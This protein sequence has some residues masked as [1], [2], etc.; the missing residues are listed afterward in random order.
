MKLTGNPTIFSLNPYEQETV[1]EHPLGA[2]GIGS[3]GD[4]YRY[5]KINAAG[6]DLIAGKLVVSRGR[7][8][9]HQNMTLSAVAA[10]GAK[11]LLPTAGA[12]AVDANEYDEG[13]LA[14]VDTS[15]EGET[16]TITAHEAN[17]GS[18]VTDFYIYPGLLTVTTAAAEVSVVRNVWN[19]P[20]ISQLIAEMAAGIPLSDWD[21]SVAGFGWLKTRGIVAGFGDTT[22]VTVG[23]RMTVSDQVDGAIGLLSDLDS[24]QQVGIAMEASVNGELQPVY[25]TID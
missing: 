12:T 6:T 1:Q 25:L 4:M 2:R 21:V 13:T 9:N 18:L 14:F 5:T 17:A 22:G 7:E 15:P 3:N 19:N 16:Y 8:V 10:K 24:E 20:L 11:L 23:Y